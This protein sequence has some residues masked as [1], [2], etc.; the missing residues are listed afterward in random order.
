MTVAWNAGRESALAIQRGP[1]HSP[2][3]RTPPGRPRS[4]GFCWLGLFFWSTRGALMLAP[5]ERTA[6]LPEV[7][8]GIN[9]CGSGSG[10][11]Q[12]R[13]LFSL[14]PALPGDTYIT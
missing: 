7:E 14:A 5:R 4:P 6:R 9:C 13:G 3:R 2:L 11:P 12:K 10:A 1:L 8:T